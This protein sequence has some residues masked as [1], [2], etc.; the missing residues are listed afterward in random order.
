[1]IHTEALTLDK[2][3]L[4]EVENRELFRLATG[5]TNSTSGS[6]SKVV[7]IVPIED[8][9]YTAQLAVKFASTV[10]ATAQISVC[11]IDGNFAS[12]S[13]ARHFAKTA[14]L[15]SALSSPQSYQQMV[16][17]SFAEGTILALAPAA[18]RDLAKTSPLLK[19]LKQLLESQISGIV[20]LLAP[21]ASD[22]MFF[23]EMAGAIDGAIVVV[24][25]NRT[26]RQKAKTAVNELSSLGFPVLGAVLAGRTFP[27][28]DFIYDRL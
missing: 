16:Q 28:P 27:I 13:I 14:S 8:D 6:A 17:T 3:G 25:A 22:L 2:T 19:Q 21:P 15:E 12:P 9:S 20:V 23:S 11:L 7:V 18:Q 26:R 5:V 10:A 24:E 4:I 1:M